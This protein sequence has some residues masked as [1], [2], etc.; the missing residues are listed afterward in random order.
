MIES[1]NCNLWITSY[2]LVFIFSVNKD[3]DSDHPVAVQVPPPKDIAEAIEKASETIDRTVGQKH[4]IEAENLET[5]AAEEQ[6]QE[7]SNDLPMSKKL[8]L[9]D[10]GIDTESEVESILSGK[11]LDTDIPGLEEFM[12]SES[13]FLCLWINCKNKLDQA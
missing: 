3:P 12:S 8:K 1:K 2:F 10:S 6:Q 4:K 13:K 7:T 11:V 9:S 5:S